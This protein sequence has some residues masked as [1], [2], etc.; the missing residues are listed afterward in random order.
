MTSEIQDGAVRATLH[1][2]SVKGQGFLVLAHGAGTNRHAP[3]LLAFAQAFCAGGFAVLR[4][5]LPFRQKR[6]SGPPL[7]AWAKEDQAGLRDAV[8]Y[9]NSRFSQPA[10]AGGHSYGG[11]QA[12]LLAAE[13]PAIADALL[14]LSYPLHPPRRPEQLRT[15][16][17]PSLKTPSFFVHG[18]RDPFGSVDE[19]KNSMSAITAPTELIVRE[20]VGHDLAHGRFAITEIVLGPFLSFLETKRA[21]HLKA[22]T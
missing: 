16:H 10:V 14:L 19:M 4:C 11:R 8:L 13:D 12:S 2:P 18:S 22:I 5:D 15:A 1:T 3:I 9:M 17:W 21:T 7:P 6:P 20:S